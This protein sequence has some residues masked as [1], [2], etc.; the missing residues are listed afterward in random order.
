MPTAAIKIQPGLLLL[1]LAMLAVR[2]T[3]GAG[4]PASVRGGN[5]GIAEGTLFLLLFQIIPRSVASGQAYI[6]LEEIC[7][8]VTNM[9]SGTPHLYVKVRS[10]SLPTSLSYQILHHAVNAANVSSSFVSYIYNLP[11]F[12]R[13]GET[14]AFIS[15]GTAGTSG[16][17]WFSSSDPRGFYYL[18]LYSLKNEE[19]HVLGG[20]T[21]GYN[22]H[23]PL[24]CSHPYHPYDHFTMPCHVYG[25]NYTGVGFAAVSGQS[26]VDD[27]TRCWKFAPLLSASSLYTQGKGKLNRTAVEHWWN[28]T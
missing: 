22:H 27:N 12:A 25:L 24:Y 5:G 11:W 21:G 15:V 8:N 16:N 9:V 26:D 10:S 4:P 7:F 19:Q 3:V 14:D 23:I 1:C 2:T 20:N 17:D 18:T 13:V 28:K 6:Y